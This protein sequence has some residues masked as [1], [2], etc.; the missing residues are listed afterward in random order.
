M[1][2]QVT[3]LAATDGTIVSATEKACPYHFTDADYFGDW[4][5]LQTDFGGGA[6]IMVNFLPA[7]AVPG[8][9]TTVRRIP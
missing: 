1:K 3:A 4:T 5:A 2:G 6:T 9:A 7:A 8:E